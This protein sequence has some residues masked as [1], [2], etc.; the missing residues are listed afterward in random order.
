LKWGDCLTKQ[1]ANLNL[2]KPDMSDLISDTITQLASNF[3]IIDSSL[4]QNTKNLRKFKPLWGLNMYVKQDLDEAKANVDI[5]V[6]LNMESIIFCVDFQDLGGTFYSAYEYDTRYKNMNYMLDYVASKGLK[7]KAIK[8]H[9]Y[10]LD[11][12]KPDYFDKYTAGINTLLT[13][14]TSPNKPDTI[15][16]LNEVNE[17]IYAYSTY[18]SRMIALLNTVKTAGYKVGI[19]FSS[20][21]QYVAGCNFNIMEKLDVIGLNLY[22]QIT[23]NVQN[24]SVTDGINAW[25]QSNLEN[26]A[27]MLKISY[28]SAEIWVSETG[29]FDNMNALTYP[30]TSWVQG[31]TADGQGTPSEIYFTGMFE[32]LKES[33]IIKGVYGWWVP[34][35]NTTKLINLSKR[36]IKGEL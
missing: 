25:K 18:G 5:A 29:V 30:G 15:T 26:T 33:E 1:T 23:S 8:I 2:N 6:S 31:Y 20:S 3:D 22:P 16:V 35:L 12:T 32:Y 4:A 9:Q 27:K 34:S 14:I 36:Y 28:P 13:Y 19:T 11:S 24:V 7:V 17:M 21:F 10:N